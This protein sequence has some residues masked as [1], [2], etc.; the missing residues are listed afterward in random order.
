MVV[1]NNTSEGCL[2][3]LGLWPIFER[4]ESMGN[5]YSKINQTLLQLSKELNTDLWTLDGFLW[6]A[7]LPVDVE[8]IDGPNLILCEPLGFGLERHL[9][10]F[11]VDNWDKTSLS[12]EWNIY[13]EPGDEEAGF[14][15]PC[16]VGRI[17]IL[18][19][20]KTKPSWLVIELKRDQTS[21]ATMGRVLRYMGWIKKEMAEPTDEVRGLIIARYPDDSLLY[22]LNVTQN[23]EFQLYE[24]EF[25]LTSIPKAI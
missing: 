9:H 15:F 20:H 24:V 13:A 5:R 1:W 7:T 23:V 3:S 6:R 21:D 25:R 4:G 12:Q 11:M 8:P 10:E 17:D 14:E 16:D 18:A 19:H 22:A 2:K